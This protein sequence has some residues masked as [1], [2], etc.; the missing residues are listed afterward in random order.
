MLGSSFLNPDLLNLELS[1]VFTASLFITNYLELFF[2]STIVKNWGRILSNVAT[3][4]STKRKN[5]AEVISKVWCTFFLVIS[6]YSSILGCYSGIVCNFW[7]SPFAWEITCIF[8]VHGLSANTF[9]AWL[10]E[11]SFCSLRGSGFCSSFFSRI[12]L[13]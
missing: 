9:F 10:I 4:F 2:L 13:V 3:L 12:T 6:I 8:L 7:G 11:S 1:L 5:N